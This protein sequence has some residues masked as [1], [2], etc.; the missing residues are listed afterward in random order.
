MVACAP[1]TLVL[2]NTGS[3]RVQQVHGSKGGVES[4]AFSL[5]SLVGVFCLLLGRLLRGYSTKAWL[6]RQTSRLCTKQT[7]LVCSSNPVYIT[8]LVCLGSFSFSSFSFFGCAEMWKV[9][10][11]GD[12]LG[13]PIAFQAWGWAWCGLVVA[14]VF[15]YCSF[16][17]CL[18][19]WMAWS[20][21]SA[22]DDSGLQMR[23]RVCGAQ[24]NTPCV[25][26]STQR[27][28]CNEIPGELSDAYCNREASFNI[29]I[30]AQCWP[31]KSSLRASFLFLWF[32]GS[33]LYFILCPRMSPNTLL[34]TYSIMALACLCH[35]NSMMLFYGKL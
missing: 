11:G 29:L 31:L 13:G 35:K 3:E 30:R 25:G 17:L 28:D 5:S 33:C 23:S 32:W 34:F 18:G 19:G 21:W 9:P 6:G 2:L 22:C 26:N 15:I 16:F 8:L 10:A 12:S 4:W 27:R 24:G 7:L 14:G 20:L 1:S